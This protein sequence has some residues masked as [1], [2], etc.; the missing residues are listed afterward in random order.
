M[1]I[2]CNEN[3]FPCN[4]AKHLRVSYPVV[5]MA[6]CALIFFVNKSPPCVFMKTV[7]RKV[8]RKKERKRARKKLIE[9]I[10]NNYFPSI[11]LFEN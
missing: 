6:F 2:G 9:Y 10:V 3:R 5:S 1:M 4:L 8:C 11:L 7:T